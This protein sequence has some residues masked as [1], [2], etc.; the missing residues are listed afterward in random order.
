VR[1]DC[2]VP[3]LRV[4]L[5][6]PRALLATPTVR[7]P[8]VGVTAP[9][10]PL[11]FDPETMRVPLVFSVSAPEPLRLPDRVVVAVLVTVRVEPLLRVPL[12]DR[13]RLLLPPMA[14]LPPTA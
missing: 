3:P 4:R 9:L 5:P 8:L 10:H 1:L 14:A 13:V 6:V 7:V 11:L 12:P 2:S